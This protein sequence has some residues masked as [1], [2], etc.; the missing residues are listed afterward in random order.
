M[1]RDAWEER[2]GVARDAALGLPEAARER[3]PDIG[4]KHVLHLPCRTGEATADLIALGALVTGIDP[5][6]QALAVAREH[7]GAPSFQA[8]ISELPLQLRRRRFRSFTPGRAP[9]AVRRFAPAVAAAPAREGLLL[10]PAPCPSADCRP[11]GRA[12]SPG[13]RRLGDIVTAFVGAGLA[14]AELDELP[15]PAREPGGR[16]DPRIPGEFLLQATKTV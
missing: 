2:F 7:V 9:L 15:P 5:S 12:T 1:N 14:L 6:E 11:G 10:R 8:E 4:G 13:R 16:H 3:L